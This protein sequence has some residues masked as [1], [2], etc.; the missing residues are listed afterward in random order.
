MQ[1]QVW[2]TNSP[3]SSCSPRSFLEKK[4]GET[5]KEKKIDENSNSSIVSI[6]GKDNS[7]MNME[8]VSPKRNAK[9]TAKGKVVKYGSDE[10]DED[11]ENIESDYV[12]SDSETEK[13]VKKT[14]TKPKP[15]VNPLNQFCYFPSVS[16]GITREEECFECS[17]AKSTEQRRTQSEKTSS[18]SIRELFFTIGESFQMKK[19]PSATT[20]T[21]KKPATTKRPKPS[22]VSQWRR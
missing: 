19:D 3:L 2:E 8:E 4:S 5:Q 17:D 20:A 9:R 13:K 11:Q 16:L 18:K 1:Q 10:E 6:D 21:S 12:G 15:A 7:E 14:K 22:A